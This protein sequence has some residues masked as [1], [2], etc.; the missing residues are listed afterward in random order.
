M[1]ATTAA[2]QKMVTGSINGLNVTVPAGTTILEAARMADIEV[3]NLCFQPL[4]RTWGSCRI[5]TVQILGKRGGLMESCATPLAEGMEVLTHSPEVMESRQFILQMYLIDHALDCPTCDKSGECYLQ[6][7]TYLHNVNANPY[8]R[9]KF[10]QSYVHFSELIDYK[11]D[12][13]IMC[14]RCTRVCDE[15][16][17]VTA[18]EIGNRSLE[19]TIA[20]AFGEDLSETN[21]THCGMCIA[22]CPVGALTDRHF[23]H[24]PWELDSTETIC[25][26]CDVGCTLNVEAN[27]GLVRRTTHLWERGVNHGYTCEYGRWGYEQVQHQDR[28]FYP[29]V[30]DE[31]AEDRTYEITWPDAIDLVAETLAHHQGERFAALASPDGTNEEAYLLQQFTR[32]VMASPNVDRLLTPAQVSVERAVEA[33]LGRDV[34]NT[35]NMQEMFS[36]AKAGLVV[37]PSIG[38]TEPVASYWFYHSS[39]YREARYVVI[40]QDNYPLCHRSPIW[41][42]PNPGATAM[43]LNGIARQ[44]VDLGL[45]SPDAGQV[46]GFAAWQAS[47]A[48]YGLE[49]V[50]AETGCDPEA[51]KAAAVLYATGGV[52]LDATPP[53]G[54]FPASLIYQTSAHLTDD[55]EAGASA[56]VAAG[57]AEDSAGG[58]DDPQA[59]AAACINLTI[60]T[61]NLG[62]PGGGVANPR[63]PANFQGV[64]DMGALPR[65]FPGGLDIA[66]NEARVRFE[67]AWLPRWADEATTSNGF[68]PVR[69][70][71]T[72]S[73]LSLDALIN[74]IDAG[75]VTAMYVENTI[76]GR[77][78]PVH[79]R[80]Y[81]SLA[82]LK[83]LVVADHYADTPLGRLAHVVL[84]LAMAMEKDGTFTSFDRT[85]QRLRASIPT[86]GEAK[87]GGVIVGAIA[88]R[89]GY[90]LEDRHP[91]LVMGEIAKIVPSYGGVSYARLE[92]GGITAPTASFADGGTP[93]LSPSADGLSAL[94]PAFTSAQ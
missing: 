18:I 50:A 37:G 78:A 40:S 66:D 48:D 15:M 72:E 52:G 19:A 65:R 22:V 54:G 41:L 17:G 10:A 85:V 91:A 81:E 49:R 28:L 44:I 16:I 86:M 33:G 38:K 43:L 60:L 3:P 57:G 87:P 62:R 36:A 68:V 25:G 20:P 56:G 67:A 39:I 6:D 51:I 74:A 23:G 76:G 5:C 82:K 11:W 83:F 94:S 92:R 2:A 29:T 13:C 31:A 89:M 58:A 14:A 26:F 63:G 84:P 9:P 12:R 90:G 32:A 34:A 61:G 73:G 8:R 30:R 7:N 69:S 47:L 80:L 77:H 45:A 59:I 71:P 53:E 75:I 88:R 1:S 55:A 21:C 93:I 46:P 42:K 64:S 70:L 4:L 79:P 24:H 35:N 27:R